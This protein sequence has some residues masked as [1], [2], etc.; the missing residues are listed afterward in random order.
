MLKG[1]QKE[2]DFLNDAVLAPVYYAGL[3]DGEGSVGVYMINTKGT[4]RGDIPRKY[5]RLTTKVTNTFH[6]ALSPLLEKFGGSIENNRASEKFT[7]WQDTYSW[8]VSSE[9]AMAFLL[10]IYP[11]TLI[12]KEQLDVVFQFWEYHTQ[13]KLKNY[14][15]PDQEKINMFIIRLKELKRGK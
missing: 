15:K 10:W 7:K 3:F 5:I 1:D 12:K 9:K 2:M 13:N 6:P 11:Y 4:D 8:K 14:N